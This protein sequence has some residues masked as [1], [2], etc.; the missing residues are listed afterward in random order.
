MGRMICSLAVVG[1]TDAL[2]LG[3]PRGW[4]TTHLGT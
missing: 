4:E 3:G 1:A 2:V